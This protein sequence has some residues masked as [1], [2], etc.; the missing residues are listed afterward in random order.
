M[1]ESFE[2][3]AN[4]SAVARQHGVNVGLLHHWR[5]RGKERAREAADADWPA[6]VPVAMSGAVDS[7]T[8][9]RQSIGR[10]I[11]IETRGEIVRVPTGADSKTLALV[12]AAL[13]RGPCLPFEAN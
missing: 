11:E 9:R 10:M 12:L 7:S 8:A 5:K 6:F 4:I 1:A 2:P 3:G 13:R